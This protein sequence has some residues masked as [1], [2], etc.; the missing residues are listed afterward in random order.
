MHET[1][2]VSLAMNAS[3]DCLESSDNVSLNNCKATKVNMKRLSSN[4]LSFDK[5]NWMTNPNIL[6]IIKDELDILK[7]PGSKMRMRREVW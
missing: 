1:L 7:M 5:G 3:M 6:E 2:G 4:C